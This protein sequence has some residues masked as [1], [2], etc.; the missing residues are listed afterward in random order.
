MRPARP[1]PAAR[2]PPS[3]FARRSATAA[4]AIPLALVATYAG[5][6]PFAMLIVMSAALVVVE[7]TRLTAP[8][9]RDGAVFLPLAALA[10]GVAAFA[11][12]GAQIAVATLLAACAASAACARRAGLAPMW[13]AAGAAYA[14]LA[15]LSLFVLRDS[16]L[17]R[18]AVLW[19]LAVVWSCD[20]AAF[21]FGRLIGGARLAPRVSPA[22]TWAGAIAALAGAALA[23][24]AAA[25][26][27]PATSPAALA[28]VG[29][30]VG[31]AAIL[32]D[33]AE[34]WIKRRFGAKNAGDLFPGHGGMMD[35]VD[36]LVLASGAAALIG[37]ARAGTESAGAG[38]LVW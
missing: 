33:L 7:W 30:G 14:G 22:K 31:I 25:M 10:A 1:A 9:A 38:L 35:R 26:L 16:E 36:S 32:G 24:A 4:I 3:E 12:A 29:T 8:A 34:S 13:T 15:A 2:C 20:T 6:A 11:L 37:A 18:A 17:G 5:G 27:L 19:L 21:V 23:G 28:A